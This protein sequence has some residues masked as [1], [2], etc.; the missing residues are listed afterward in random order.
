V[1]DSKGVGQAFEHLRKIMVRGGCGWVAMCIVAMTLLSPTARASAAPEGG[2]EVYR[3]WQ[4]MADPAPI[5]VDIVPGWEIDD[6]MDNVEAKVIDI[7]TCRRRGKSSFLI[8]P[9]ILMVH[10]SQGRMCAA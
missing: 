1:K 5:K 3:V 9:C 8:L 7:N 10:V 6:L 4:S 2:L